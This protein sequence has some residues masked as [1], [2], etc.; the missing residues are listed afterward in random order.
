[1]SKVILKKELNIAE[2]RRTKS[3]ITHGSAAILC[4]SIPEKSDKKLKGF[5]EKQ[6]ASP[7]RALFDTGKAER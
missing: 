3:K 1:M 7:R 2:R 5:D 4:K 6:S